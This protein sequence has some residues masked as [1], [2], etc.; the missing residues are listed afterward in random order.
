MGRNKYDW[1]QFSQSYLHFAKLGCQELLDPKHNP[2]DDANLP[3]RYSAG[4]IVPI[5][6]NIKH[7]I[8]IYIKTISLIVDEKYDEGHNVHELFSKLKLKLK[9]VNLKPFEDGRG[10]NITQQNIDD[11][12]ENLDKIER[13]I[14]EFYTVNL[15]RTKLDK[16]FVIYDNQND[17]FRYPDNKASIQIDWNAILPKFNEKNV[18]GIKKKIDDL[19]RLFS[20]MGYII[21]ILGKR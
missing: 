12:P 20:E 4:L 15:L 18:S 7:G 14:E 8:E 21:N 9:K 3:G 5:Y 16:N 10:N 2:M 17:I 11:F 1:L 6:Y 19:Y 13:L